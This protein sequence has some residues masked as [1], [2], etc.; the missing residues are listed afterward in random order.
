MN[1]SHH[2]MRDRSLANGRKSVAL[3]REAWDR[4]DGHEYE[5]NCD[6]AGG[7]YERRGKPFLS[8]LRRN[9]FSL[10]CH[11]ASCWVL[12]LR[13]WIKVNIK[14][15]KNSVAK[16]ATVRPP[17]TAR[18]SGAFC[19]PPSP[20]PSAIGSMPMIIA[21]A[22]MIMGR[23]RVKPAVT[24]A[25][26]GATPLARSSLAKVTSR[27]EL[28]VATPIDMI[29]PIRL[30]TLKVVCVRKSAHTIPQKAPGKAQMMMNGSSQLW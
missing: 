21:H 20:M 7:P 26:R 23:S 15:T 12:A 28:A 14:G 9:G 18:A 17:M 25:S 2:W 3:P 16:V 19:S 27:I 5:N 6:N 24:A 13:R 8:L 4:T 29:A 10:L 30:G 11:A 22:V 1:E